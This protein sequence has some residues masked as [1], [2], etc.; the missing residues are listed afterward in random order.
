MKH[1]VYVPVT[2]ITQLLTVS[3]HF[4]GTWLAKVKKG[5]AVAN[6]ERQWLW[7]TARQWLGQRCIFHKLRNVAEKCREEL[8][9]EANKE[10][11]MQL[12]EQASVIYKTRERS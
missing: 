12:V 11:R 10:T 7:C 5:M 4:S 6:W 9:G 3:S 2:M 1:S 8:K